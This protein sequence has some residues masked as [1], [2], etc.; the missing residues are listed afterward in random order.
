MRVLWNV[1]KR[2]V[3]GVW[4]SP[5]D[6]YLWRFSSKSH[7]KNSAPLFNYTLN[8]HPGPCPDRELFCSVS[9]LIMVK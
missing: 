4:K 2:E 6:V 1:E 7:H 5:F 8:G 3:P 9:G